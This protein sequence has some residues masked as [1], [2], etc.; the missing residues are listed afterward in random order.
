LTTSE[1]H[2]IVT[3][4]QGAGQA[5]LFLGGVGQGKSTLGTVFVENTILPRPGVA[6]GPPGCAVELWSDWQTGSYEPERLA[7]F[8]PN[9][10]PAEHHRLMYYY[11]ARPD[12]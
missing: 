4:D 1:P 2:R 3:L 6:Y 5:S 8:Y 7:G 10:D 9:D 12:V 11:L